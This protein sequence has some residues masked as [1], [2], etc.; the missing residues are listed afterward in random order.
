MPDERIYCAKCGAQET[1]HNLLSTH[2][3]RYG[4]KTF[5]LCLQCDADLELLTEQWIHGPREEPAEPVNCNCSS[6]I[7]DPGCLLYEK[8]EEALEKRLSVIEKSMV[9]NED[10]RHTASKALWATANDIQRLQVRVDALEG[11]RVPTT[12]T[13]R[14]HQESIKAIHK[15]LE[16][17]EAL[18][19]F[20]PAV[21][22]P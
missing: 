19:S 18:H 12:E 6:R 13:L 22:S 16:R 20:S 14:N 3:A 21:E 15:H 11:V 9:T 7:H 5:L 17:F 4:S 10:L 1:D 8:P 2:R